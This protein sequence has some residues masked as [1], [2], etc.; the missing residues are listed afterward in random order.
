MEPLFRFHDSCAEHVV[1]RTCC[2]ESRGMRTATSFLPPYG[3]AL[4]CRHL[5][6]LPDGAF[7]RRSPRLWSPSSIRNSGYP[8]EPRTP[9]KAGRHR[10]G[11]SSATSGVRSRG[12]QSWMRTRASGRQHAGRRLLRNCT[13]R[14]QSLRICRAGGK[15]I[16][17]IHVRLHTV[18][19]RHRGNGVQPPL[20]QAQ[21]TVR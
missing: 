19:P 4:G 1:E 6:R 11:G 13:A 20:K 15:N 8:A 16:E 14:R 5:R 10:G 3:M 2:W 21:L 12:R 9:S 17:E 18:G 7:S